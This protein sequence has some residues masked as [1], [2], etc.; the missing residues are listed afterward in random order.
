MPEDC[1]LYYRKKIFTKEFDNKGCE[2]FDFHYKSKFILL[3]KDAILRIHTNVFDP[4]FFKDYTTQQKDT[5]PLKKS[6]Y[7]YVKPIGWK[8]Y[9][10]NL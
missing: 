5:Q 6:D 4:N 2:E 8:K 9:G 7:L 1:V 3:K 10:F